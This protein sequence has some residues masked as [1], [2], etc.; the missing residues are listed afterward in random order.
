MYGDKKKNDP[1]S[2]S[3]KNIGIGPIGWYVYII[4]KE[5]KNTFWW[6]TKIKGIFA[7]NNPEALHELLNNK[8]ILE[9]DTKNLFISL[10]DEQKEIIKNLF[11][12][13]SNYFEEAYKKNKSI[14]VVV[15]TNS[16]LEGNLVDYCIT[17]ELYYK[18]DYIYYY[19]A[20]PETPIEND[21]AKIERLKKINITYVDSNI[22][23]EMIMYYNPNISCSGYYSSSF[24]EVD[25]KKLKAL[26]EQYK[27]EDEYFNKFDYFCQYIKKDEKKYGKYLKENNDGTVLEINKKKLI[28][29]KYDFGIYLKNNKTIEYYTYN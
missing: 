22:P 26:F 3:P 23:L 13:N 27:K 24:I 15:G 20:H 18:D 11:S 21:K 14:M 5:E 16:N 29:F 12:L 10:G 8:N 1:S 9:K 28:E 2:P 7:P 25:K 4:L 19:K 6:L 17:T